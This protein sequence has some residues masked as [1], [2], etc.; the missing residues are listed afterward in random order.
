MTPQEEAESLIM[1]FA[2]EHPEFPF[3]NDTECIQHGKRSASI[4]VSIMLK[5]LYDNWY[6]SSNG[7]FE[8]Y[9]QVRK[10]I[11]SYVG[12]FQNQMLC[13]REDNE[14]QSFKSST[15][16]ETEGKNE[17]AIRKDKHNG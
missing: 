9:I 2:R 7:V 6:D 10:Q 17:R 3:V 15:D 14:Q 4:A 16:G 11:K 8:H 13:Y 1:I 12:Q 5:V